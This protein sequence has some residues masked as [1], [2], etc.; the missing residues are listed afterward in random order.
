MT[1][2]FSIHNKG[3]LLPLKLATQWWNVSPLSQ[4]LEEVWM[5]WTKANWTTLQFYSSKFVLENTVTKLV[6][7]SLS[8]NGTTDYSWTNKWYYVFQMSAPRVFFMVLPSTLVIERTWCFLMVWSAPATFPVN[9]TGKFLRHSN[10][11]E[12]KTENVQKSNT[13]EFRSCGKGNAKIQK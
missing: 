10:E 13:W 5:N 7:F 1:F 8:I 3:L 11:E 6:S 12:K 9:E 4:R 2:Y